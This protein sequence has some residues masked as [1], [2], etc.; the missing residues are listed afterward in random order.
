MD[1]NTPFDG[2]ANNQCREARNSSHQAAQ[3]RAEE[4]RD[5]RS[6]I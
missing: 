4:P 2:E 3:A 5:Y 6:P 1:P